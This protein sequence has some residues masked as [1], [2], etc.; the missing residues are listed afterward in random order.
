MPVYL[1]YMRTLQQGSL[2]IA[3]NHVGVGNVSHMVILSKKSHHP[4]SFLSCQTSNFEFLVISSGWFSFHVSD[5]AM[6]ID[7]GLNLISVWIWSIHL[8]YDRS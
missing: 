4:S 1:L 2:F 7:N 5:G 6:R 3:Y 8:S